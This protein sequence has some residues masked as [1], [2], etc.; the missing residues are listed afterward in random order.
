MI[1]VDGFWTGVVVGFL[2]TMTGTMIAILG[3]ARKQEKNKE[4]F[5]KFLN[6]LSELNE[7]AKEKENGVS[8]QKD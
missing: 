1:V 4:Q 5:G 2:A 7:L 6:K 8:N 3:L